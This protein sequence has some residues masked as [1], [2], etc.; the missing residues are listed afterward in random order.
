[1]S[2]AEAGNAHARK[3]SH[4]RIDLAMARRKLGGA[5]LLARRGP[6]GVFGSGTELEAGHRLK[7][8]AIQASRELVVDLDPE[9]FAQAHPSR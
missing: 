1:M 2:T 6:A 8:G 5:G 4:R 9:G 7:V 3:T